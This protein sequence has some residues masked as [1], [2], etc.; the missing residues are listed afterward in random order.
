MPFFVRGPGISHGRI[1]Q[2]MVGNVDLAPTFLDIAGVPIPAHMDGSS[3]L[4]FLK[5]EAKIR[6]RVPWRDTYLIERGKIPPPHRIN[7][8]QQHPAPPAAAAAAPPALPPSSEGAEGDDS[9]AISV[10]YS[11]VGGKFER[12]AIE[13]RKPRYQSPCAPFQTYQC[14][15][16]VGGDRWRMQK[17]RAGAIS[18]PPPQLKR[19]WCKCKAL[20]RYLHLH[21]NSFNYFIDLLFFSFFF[22]I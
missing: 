8:N 5:K 21:S 19:Q 2:S 3:M 13:C 15:L 7:K 14:V 16:D 9:D 11:N 18:R 10:D 6:S 20:S 4:R 22:F 17:C 12:W 1:V